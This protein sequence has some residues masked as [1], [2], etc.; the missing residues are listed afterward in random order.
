MFQSSMLAANADLPFLRHSG[1]GTVV[2]KVAAG[3]RPWARGRVGHRRQLGLQKAGQV[4]ACGGLEHG[5][6]HRVGCAPP[7]ST[8]YPDS[9]AR[10]R[11]W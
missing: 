1:T 4:S 11:L 3:H 9:P 5:D 2:T 6:D 8:P 7:K 10:H